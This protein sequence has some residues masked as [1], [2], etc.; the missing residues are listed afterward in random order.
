MNDGP[1][2][3]GQARNAAQ[4]LMFLK[5][6]TAFLSPGYD[7]RKMLSQSLSASPGRDSGLTPERV[8]ILTIAKHFSYDPKN[9]QEN[10]PGKIILCRL[11]LTQTQNAGIQI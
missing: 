11:R 1:I 2:R 7:Y 4:K 8:A 10:S 3:E 6:H 5:T 9:N